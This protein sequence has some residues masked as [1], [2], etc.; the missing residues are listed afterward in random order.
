MTV[1]STDVRA[2]VARIATN[3]ALIGV[4]HA[5]RAI[6]HGV[7][8]TVRAEGI[9]PP[10]D[11]VTLRNDGGTLSRL[12]EA[13]RFGVSVLG[14]GQMD[15]AIRFARPEQASG[16]RVAQVSRRD[17]EGVPVIDRCHAW[18]ASAVDGTAPFGSYT[19][20][21]DDVRAAGPGAVE[22]PLLYHAQGFGRLCVDEGGKP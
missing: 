16:T 19:I 22:E 8:A 21:V 20:V 2:A 1:P 3:V 4:R 17:V 5:D 9:Q 11:L 7:T 15:L 12:I 14:E 18:F 10:R 6:D 13:G